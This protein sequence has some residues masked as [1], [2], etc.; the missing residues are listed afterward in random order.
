ML[1]L[2]VSRK[3]MINLNLKTKVKIPNLKDIC[4]K[5]PLNIVIAQRNINSLK[6]ELD[7]FTE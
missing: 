2:T 3:A 6:N 5:S 7:L 1:T 4:K